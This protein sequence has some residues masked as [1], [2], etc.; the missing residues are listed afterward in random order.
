MLK[1]EEALAEFD[2]SIDDWVIKL[3][4]A[5]NRRTRV[6]QKLLEHVAAAATLPNPADS[7]VAAAQL[8]A[9]A[10]DL[11]TP[12]QSPAKSGTFPEAELPSS[13]SPQR[14]VARV[15]SVIPELPAEEE[16][17]NPRFTRRDPEE[18]S[19]VKRMESIRIYADSDVYA[20]LA[21]VENEFTKINGGGVT[22]PEELAHPTTDYNQR[23]LHRALSHDILSGSSKNSSTTASQH[24]ISPTPSPLARS[25]PNNSEGSVLLTAAVFR[26]E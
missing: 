6:R 22:T 21:D 26:P 2:A 10:S 19:T 4:H 23:D 9:S 11:S 12:P 15:P 24:T 8:P 17:S 3:E 13:Q 1:Q 16:D 20:L 5:E 25:S 14:V 7:E 18:E